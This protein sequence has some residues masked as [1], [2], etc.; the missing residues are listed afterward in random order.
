MCMV[1]LL[2]AV[3]SPCTAPELLA[4]LP[5]ALHTK[6]ILKRNGSKGLKTMLS[7]HWVIEIT[8]F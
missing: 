6:S 7:R 5:C 3:P 8:E 4:S 2:Q 1:A